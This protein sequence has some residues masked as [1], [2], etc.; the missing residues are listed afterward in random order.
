MVLIEPKFSP[1]GRNTYQL[2]LDV[3]KYF[4]DALKELDKLSGATVGI[5]CLIASICWTR[6][7]LSRGK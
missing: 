5:R 4:F 2:V 7:G 1:K 6:Q 3:Y